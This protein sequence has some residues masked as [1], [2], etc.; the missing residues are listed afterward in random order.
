MSGSELRQ[1]IRRL[2]ARPGFTALAILTLGLGIG[3]TV[4]I[5]SLVYG[6]LIRPLPYAESER[7]VMLWHTAPALGV[8]EFNQSYGSY[9]HY[10]EQGESFE[11]VALYDTRTFN[12]IGEGEPERLLA[13]RASASLFD[14]LRV[15][16]AVGRL[17]D[18]EEDQP[19]GPQ[20]V[21]LGHGYWQ[22]RFGGSPS[23]IGRTVQLSESA[24]EVIGVMPEG[25]AFP[26]AEVDLWVPHPIDPADL[27]EV[28]F[29]FDAVA[30]LRPGVTPEQASIEV[31]SLLAR[32]PD[33]YPGA[34][35]REMIAQSGIGAYVTPLR[36][37]VVGSIAQILWVLLATVGFVLL[38]A[39]ANV[40]NLVLVRTEGRQRELAVCAA[41]GA[42][43]GRLTRQL[44]LES[45]VL[46][47]GGGLLGI[48][49]AWVGIRL[50]HATDPV[51][52][53]RLAEVTLSAPVLI[54]AL[55]VSLISGLAFGILPTLR[56][57]GRRMGDAL[58]ESGRGGMA[59]KS[60][61]RARSTLVV[62]QMALAL[63]LLVGSALMLRTFLALRSVDTGFDRSSVLTMRVSLSG[64]RYEERADRAQFWTRLVD[65]IRTLPGVEHA[66]G[67]LNL[68]LTD[69][70]TNPGYIIEDFPPQPDD[71]PTVASQNVVVDG[72]FEAMGIPI[73]AGRTIE[74]RDASITN[75]SV[76]VSAAFARRFWG[77]ASPI[78][79]RLK[80]GLP[81]AQEGVW[82]TIVGVAGDVRDE[83]LDAAPEEVV[84]FPLLPHEDEDNSGFTPSVMSL[85]LL[86]KDGIDPTSLTGALRDAVRRSDPSLPLL[87]PRTTAEIASEAMARTTFAMIM[88][89]IA[90]AVAL[91]LGTIGIYGVLSHAVIQRTR[92]I[93]VRLALG[94]APAQVRGM[95]VSQ[96]MRLAAVGTG[97]GLI[98]ALLLAHLL[99]ALLFGV[100]ARDPLTYFG[101]A[102]I[103]IA[104]AA[105]AS[106]LPARRAARIAPTE[107]LRC[108]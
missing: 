62:A 5:F 87:R 105:I 41:L 48:S 98:G 1:L 22:R 24:W 10:R 67:V 26:S 18:A 107:A 69:G 79:K 65:E 35:S 38:I 8:E 6:I 45:L 100:E 108:E 93:G 73:V 81:T 86:A 63:M 50:L 66:G 59:G 31:D 94:A 27:P 20:V 56:L 103:L 88:L 11:E 7:L 19:G 28:D 17:F 16:A 43:R 53:P 60:T 25:F 13:T 106:F 76:V 57:H 2:V 71:P 96:G 23:V 21:V 70:D 40:A 46:A 42:S 55:V 99:A 34:L 3:A 12:L 15:D 77:D 36:D 44:L 61:H 90:A 49:L 72:Y 82:Y 102:V 91:L 37:S 33:A 32:L 104:V 101:V 68:P 75:D 83:S 92:E 64:E 39:C 29:S 84:Y 58:V 30:R 14:V 4:A 89:A 95:L 80:R 74:R 85:T 52:L 51:D 78:G 54:F 9:T 47:A 97:I